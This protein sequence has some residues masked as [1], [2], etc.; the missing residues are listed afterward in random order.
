MIIQH[1]S[2]HNLASA[3]SN[4]PLK[5]LPHKN[6]II[7]S[8]FHRIIL[9]IHSEDQSNLETFEKN[10][11]EDDEFQ[12][13]I[14]QATKSSESIDIERYRN[15]SELLQHALKGKLEEIQK[16]QTKILVLQ[17]VV[18][19]FKLKSQKDIEDLHQSKR[20]EIDLWKDKLLQR[21]RQSDTI[22]LQK[23][24]TIQQLQANLHRKSE[25]HL[26][27]IAQMNTEK[28]TLEQQIHKDNIEILR[29]NKELNRTKTGMEALQ[30]SMKTQEKEF[31]ILYLRY[32]SLLQEKEENKILSSIKHSTNS[33]NVE[34][35]EQQY[36]SALKLA[37]EAETMREETILIA[38]AAVKSAEERERE[39]RD[40]LWQLQEKLLEKEENGP[41]IMTLQS[42][43][44]M[45]EI[46]KLQSI[47]IQTLEKTLFEERLSHTMKYSKE[48]AYYQ[49]Q[50]RKQEQDF[51]K[52]MES[53]KERYEKELYE[54]RNQFGRTQ[55][56]TTNFV[57][58]KIGNRILRLWKQVRFR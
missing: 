23:A 3:F 21:K 9:L 54:I 44:N 42:P 26:S 50:L 12:N 34:E 7:P 18:K 20:D 11:I 40:Q 46:Q 48:V 32:Q 5:T 16:L 43:P 52:Q 49:Q 4:R 31:E 14:A 8:T 19:R 29:L 45:T 6:Q 55:D 1:F 36:Q 27:L 13:S 30:V 53:Q 10:N 35:L 38:S 28:L 25:E 41:T 58:S 22:I 33:S 17:D 51:Q 24:K 2:I 37:Q 39:L 47:T 57:I 56:D 15:R